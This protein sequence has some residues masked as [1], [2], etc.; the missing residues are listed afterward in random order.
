MHYYCFHSALF[1][2]HV[3]DWPIFESQ[4]ASWYR[5][6][7]QA[8]TFCFLSLRRCPW[9][10]AMWNPIGLP[11]M[12]TGGIICPAGKKR[13]YLQFLGYKTRPIP[14]GGVIISPGCG[15]ADLMFVE[16][17]E[18]G[19]GYVT[20]HLTSSFQRHEGLHKHILPCVCRFQ[21]HCFTQRALKLHSIG[22]GPKQKGRTYKAICW[23]SSHCGRF[24]PNHVYNHLNQN[25]SDC[26]V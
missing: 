13:W 10:T 3:Y 15:P 7:Y 16:M 20:K 24:V 1:F 21:T 5:K 17:G 8:M 6:Q 18:A 11:R 26:V 14:W 23:F 4:P 12:Q 19:C 25:K 9:V 22:T 2:T